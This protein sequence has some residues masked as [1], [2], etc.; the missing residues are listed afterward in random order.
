MFNELSFTLA[1]GPRA[2]GKSKQ[3]KLI[4][5]LANHGNV[6][7]GETS[8]ILNTHITKN[9]RIGLELQKHSDKIKKGMIVPADDLVFE[10]IMQW[11]NAIRERQNVYHVLL[12]GSPRSTRQSVLWKQ[13]S[14][15]V[16]VVHTR[17]TKS[18]VAEG[19]RLRQEETG[20]VRHDEFEEAVETA[21]GEYKEKIEP[22]LEVF[23]GHVLHN[24]RSEPMQKRLEKTINHMKIP[25]Q[26]K[27]RWIKRLNQENHPVAIKVRMLDGTAQETMT[28]SQR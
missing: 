18:Q 17:T 22:G 27:V 11:V 19:I 28:C 4:H 3:L 20:I 16:R 7:F 14:H 9:T 13:L 15:P 24:D 25:P 8:E 12:S 6:V 1:T 5:E 21:W 26:I 10:A 23:N 2:C